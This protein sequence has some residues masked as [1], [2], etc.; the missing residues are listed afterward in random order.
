MRASRS[1]RGFTMIELMIVVAILGI[2][3]S[4]AY[5]SYTDYVA[6]T[7]RAD[8]QS[9]LLENMQTLERNFTATHQ[10]DDDGSGA[11]PTL[12]AQ[13][14]KVGTAI[15]TIAA[16]TLTDTTYTI[17]AT[18]VSGGPMA[19]DVCGVL[20]ITQTGEKQVGTGASVPQCWK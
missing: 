14:P 7:R 20:G 19:S 18:P 15:Y 17:Q 9:V 12:I 2:L 16:S 5:P 6:R 4:I 3:A 10:Y 13:S 1:S 11:A 8:A